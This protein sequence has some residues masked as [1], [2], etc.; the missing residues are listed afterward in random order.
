[1]V[2]WG[3]R[4]VAGLEAVR[5]V[6]IDKVMPGGHRISKPARMVNAL[7]VT[8]IRMAGVMVP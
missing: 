1:M 6:P 8:S 4:M 2:L 3:I 7:V 5:V